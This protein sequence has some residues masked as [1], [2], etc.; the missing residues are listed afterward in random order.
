[1]PCFLRMFEF[2]PHLIEQAALEMTALRYFLSVAS[3]MAQLARE[4]THSFPT[5][6]SYICMNY[7]ANLDGDS[8][9][10]WRFFFVRVC[11]TSTGQE[12]GIILVFHLVKIGLAVFGS[13]S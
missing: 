8:W 12:P 5:R 4:L 2:D 11:V 13:M 9:R 6:G 7:L 3:A 1:M 10:F